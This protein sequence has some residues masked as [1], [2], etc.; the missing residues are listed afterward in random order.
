VAERIYM[1]ACLP[2]GCR[3]SGKLAAMSLG[4]SQN[5]ESVTFVGSQR[6][7]SNPRLSM[8]PPLTLFSTVQR[9]RS[10]GCR[11]LVYNDYAGGGDSTLVYDEHAGGKVNAGIRRTGR[12]EGI[13]RATREGCQALIH[14]N[15]VGGENLSSAKSP[16]GVIENA[17]YAP[18]NWTLSKTTVF[19]GKEKKKGKKKEKRTC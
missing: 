10:N 5:Q 9:A 13:E 18:R 11:A 2:E 15:H 8:Q 3:C 14:D 7:G 17:G 4:P 19:H 12:G 6:F 1:G 16:S